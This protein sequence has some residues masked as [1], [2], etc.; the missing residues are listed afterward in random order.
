MEKVEIK[1]VKEIKIMRHGKGVWAG[2]GLGFLSGYLIGGIIRVLTTESLQNDILD[3]L[4][5]K[6]W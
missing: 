6:R 2:M 4:T 5:K 3:L 1:N